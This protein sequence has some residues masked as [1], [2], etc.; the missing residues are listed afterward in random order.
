MALTEVAIRAA[1]AGEKPRKIFDGAGLF[2]LVTP[3]GSRLWRFKFQHQGREK[4]LALGK[5]P[6]VSLRMA[7]DRR[8]AARRQLAEGIDPTAERRAE[9]AATMETFKAIALEWLD[10][11]EAAVTERVQARRKR[12][13]EQFLFPSLGSTPVAQVRAP[14]LLAAL[15]R[16]EVRGKNE[17]AHRLRSECGAVF[18]YAIATGR[19]DRD[20]ASALRGALAPVVVRNH[21]SI[22]DPARIGELLRAIDGYRG[23][24]PTEYALKLLPLLFVRPG[25]LRL[26]PWSEISFADAMWRIPGER[27]KMRDPH[28]VPLSTQAIALLRELKASSGD[29]L[30]LF[31]SVRSPERP[32][33]NNT[34]NAA[35]RRMGFTH[36]QIVSHG[37]RSMASTSLNE[38]GWHPDLIELQLAH[39][40]RNEVR[41]AYNR[42]QRIDERRK[43]MQA[44]ADYLGGLKSRVIPRAA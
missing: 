28:L 5:Y 9:R 12:R 31:P 16:V 27:M 33:S 10:S 3:A 8:D 13:F 6:D 39:A 21:A 43:M 34:L 30:L 42:A 26:A 37:F 18:R 44:W 2:L 36:D 17:T 29:G 32:I 4:L 20:P 40:E 25:E 24:L 19:A 35:L 11:R 38:Q 14:D 23:H 1:K 15:R 7:R 22:T 41:S